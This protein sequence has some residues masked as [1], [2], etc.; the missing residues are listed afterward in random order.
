MTNALQDAWFNTAVGRAT[1][2]DG[3]AGYQCVDVPKDYFETLT[4]LSWKEGW[5]GAGNAKDMLNTANPNYWD[6]V[7]NSQDPNLLPDYG[8]IVVYAGN[9]VNPYGH[10]GVNKSANIYGTR[11]VDQDGFLQRAMLE[12]ELTWNNYGTGPVLG[13]LKP[14]FISSNEAVLPNQRVTGPSGVTE[15]T[16]PYIRDDNKTGNV[17]PGDRILTF[18]GFMHGDSANGTDIWFRGAFGK[19]WFHSSAFEDQGTHDL[20]DL[21]PAPTPAPAVNQSVL[22]Y[23]RVTGADGANLRVAADKNAALV[24][25]FGADLILDFKGY[26]V[27]TDPFGDGRKIWFVGKYSDTFAWQG[28]FLDEDTHDLPDLTAQYLPAAQPAPAVA[29]YDFDL[30]FT[31]LTREDGVVIQVEK[32]PADIGN[33]QKGNPTADHT[34]AVVHQFGTPNVDTFASTNSQFSNAGTFVSAYWSVSGRQVRQHV[35]LADRAFHAGS[36]GNDYIGI[37][38]DPNQDPET[39]LTVRALL[40]ALKQKEGTKELML[41]RN[42]PKCSTKCGELINLDNYRSAVSDVPVVTPAPTPAPEPTPTPAPS[43]ELSEEQLEVV[44]GKVFDR[45]IQALSTGK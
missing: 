12:D 32:S 6:V 28:A 4:G 38:T 26:V 43:L 30:D 23:Q 14:K 41:H 40:R 11:L 18:D 15:R 45:L 5:P 1:D 37:E 22:P 36:V 25:T 10:I 7:W 31:T 20:P 29:K 42:V 35:S 34:K 3:V 9:D 27:G 24:K 8:D 13:W 16:S 17:Y 2:P 21:T 44:V 33:L 19:K 39:I